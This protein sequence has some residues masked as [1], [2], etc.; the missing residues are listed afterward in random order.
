MFVIFH[1]MHFTLGIKHFQHSINRLKPRRGV[2]AEYSYRI[3]LLC[4]VWHTH[5][6]QELFFFKK[7]KEKKRCKNWFEPDLSL[8]FF[9]WCAEESCGKTWDSLNYMPEW[10]HCN[11]QMTQWINGWNRFLFYS[12]FIYSFNFTSHFVVSILERRE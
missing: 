12:L 7:D 1:W 2:R 10:R 3:W 8:F 4:Y 11:L 5:T 6:T 9:V